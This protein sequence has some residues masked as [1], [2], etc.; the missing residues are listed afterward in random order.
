LLP[1][2][3]FALDVSVALEQIFS[4]CSLS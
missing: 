1:G 4:P 3:L 2:E